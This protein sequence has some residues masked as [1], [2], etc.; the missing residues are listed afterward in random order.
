METERMERRIDAHR[1]SAARRSNSVRAVRRL[2]IANWHPRGQ[3]GRRLVD[4]G[5]CRHRAAATPSPAS[6]TP[7]QAASSEWSGARCSSCTFVV[8]VLLTVLALGASA[9]S[10]ATAVAGRSALAT[11][12]TQHVDAFNQALA[13]AHWKQPRWSSLPRAADAKAVGYDKQAQME[14]EGMNGKG[15][16]KGPRY[17]S[18]KAIADAFRSGSVALQNELDRANEV[19]ARGDDAMSVMREA[20]TKGRPDR[21]HG[22][23]RGCLSGHCQAE[24]RGPALDHLQL[25]RDHRVGEGHRH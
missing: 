13:K 11:E 8:G 15:S 19:H 4:P 1:E 14:A 16:G 21:L 17:A 23:G 18:L 5:N 9:Q 7:D 20:A 22:R 2:G 6:G 10:I 24:R 3:P 12:L 25:R